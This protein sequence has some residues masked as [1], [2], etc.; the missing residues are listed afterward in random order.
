MLCVLPFALLAIM[1]CK[2]FGW[3]THSYYQIV[4]AV[5]LGGGHV[6]GVYL[7]KKKGL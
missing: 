6:L 4:L 5:A 7:V 1:I 3:S 2:W